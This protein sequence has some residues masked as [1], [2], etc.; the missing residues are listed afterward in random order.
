M[1]VE[2]LVCCRICLRTE[3]E[4]KNLYEYYIEDE[5]YFQMYQFCIGAFNKSEIDE[6][7]ELPTAICDKCE[8]NLLISYSFLKQCL[9]SEEYLRKTLSPIVHI[10]VQNDVQIELLEGEL[11]DETESYLKSEKDE[12][13][14]ESYYD[15]EAEEKETQNSISESNE[16]ESMQSSQDGTSKKRKLRTREKRTNNGTS[17]CPICGKI[18]KHYNLQIHLITHENLPYEER[19]FVC[20]LCGKRF[21]KKDTLRSHK[22]SHTRELKYA[23]AFCDKKFHVWHTRKQHVMQYHTGEYSYQCNVCQ[24]KFCVSSSYKKHMRIHTGEKLPKKEKCDICSKEF[25][26]PGR[27]RIHLVSHSQERNVKCE[28]CDKTYKTN[29][30][31]KVHLRNHTGE[32]NYECPVCGVGFTQNLLLRNHVTSKHPE[33][34]LPPPGTIL[35]K[36]YLEKVAIENS[37]K[38][39]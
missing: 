12:Q 31:L 4:L 7:I 10:P 6:V 39:F 23:C 11:S 1:S 36:K 13:E 5:N 35:N 38:I 26:N 37:K 17:I 33:Y 3:D 14:Q 32:K 28:F 22:Q 20:E 29:K 25:E 27:L 18:I 9:K 15:H 30:S 2:I 21:K 8:N 34:E 19:P 24:Q 16:S